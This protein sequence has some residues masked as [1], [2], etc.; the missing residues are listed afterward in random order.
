MDLIL[1]G[2]PGAGKGTQSAKICEKLSLKHVSTGDLL[3]E[4][5]KKGTEIGTKAK[6]LIDAGHLVPD[7]VM[8]SLIR[9]VLTS[10][11]D[12]GLLL[13]GFP[14]TIAQAESLGVLL[15]TYNR[16]VNRAVFLEVPSNYLVERLEGRR[17]CSKCGATFH[18][19]SSPPKVAGVCD[20][21]GGNL[22]QRKDDR[23]EVIE[24]RLQ[25]YEQNTLPLKKFYTDR[26]ELSTVDG[27]GS[28]DL[29]LERILAALKGF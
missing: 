2:P 22:E 23:R 14:R 9:E 27:V 16:K 15:K 4:S 11:K 18:V 26:N 17:V 3:R 19:S 12:K 13:D 25:V 24:N 21:C 29:V 1:F 7:D 5:I 8:I 28:T 10:N 6:A 20:K